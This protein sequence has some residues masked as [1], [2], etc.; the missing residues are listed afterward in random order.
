MISEKE[1]K[2]L[3]KKLLKAYYEDV[4]EQ[5]I[6]EI[7]SNRDV[8]KESFAKII[9]ALCGVEVDYSNSFSNN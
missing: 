7:F 6:E 4:F 5:T 9:S 8:N 2:K 1:Y 3:F